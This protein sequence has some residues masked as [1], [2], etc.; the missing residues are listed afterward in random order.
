MH[1]LL[2]LPLTKT[3]EKNQYFKFRNLSRMGAKHSGGYKVLQLKM[4]QEVTQAE[5]LAGHQSE[6]G[7][8]GTGR[9]RR[10]WMRWC[11]CA[12]VS[13]VGGRRGGLDG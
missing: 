12:C 6:G 2:L 9:R 8:G 7:E 1:L 3:N 10:R 13:G 11:V 4:F 5:R